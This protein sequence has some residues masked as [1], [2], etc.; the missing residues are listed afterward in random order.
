MTPE[1]LLA[2]AQLSWLQEFGRLDDI[3]REVLYSRHG[4]FVRKYADA[5]LHADASN[6]RLMRPVWEQF[7]KKYGLEE[8]PRGVGRR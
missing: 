2:R 7:I 3:A 8:N 5:W 1:E 6:K 4:A